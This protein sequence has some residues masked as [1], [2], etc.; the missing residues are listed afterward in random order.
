VRTA[1]RKN[2]GFTLIELLVVIAIIAILLAL[3]LPAVQQ[4]REAARRTQCKNNLKQIALGLHNYE[5]SYGVFPPGGVTRIPV[6]NCNIQGSSK[7]NAM[8]PW[9][10][11]LLPFL[12]QSNRYQQFNFSEV[13]N[14]TFNAPTL[15]S[16]WMSPNFAAQIERNPSYECPSD[17][18]SGGQFA[19]LN[20]FGVQGGGTPACYNSEPDPQNQLRV[21]HYNGMFH[22][23]SRVRIGDVTDGTSNVFMVGETRYLSLAN[24]YPTGALTWASALYPDNNAQLAVVLAGAVEPINSVDLNPARENTGNYQ[25]RLFG[26]HHTGGC[27]FAYV[28]G[29]V[30]FFNE[31]ADL[32]VYQQSANR[33]DGLP[34]GGE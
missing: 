31:S 26:S 28:D 3:L 8:A 5:S 22:N 27:H 32:N 13:F 1:S 14:A 19:N 16:F 11:L 2:R 20:Y 4:V 18:N 34:L 23:N 9:T 29:S 15:G 7:A 33:N 24:G 25:S 12:E 21:F 10:V 17:P 6:S 30:R